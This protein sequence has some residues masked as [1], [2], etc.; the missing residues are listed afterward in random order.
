M[1]WTYSG[2]PQDTDRDL[3]RF[4]LGDSAQT[5]Q[6]LSDEE[7]D[8]LLNVNTDAA[9]H[10][11]AYRAAAEAAGILHTRYSGLSS[12]MKRVGD[13]T[14]EVHYSEQARL[15]GLLEAKLMKGRT[16]FAI[17]VPQFFDTS[18]NVFSVGMTDSNGNDPRTR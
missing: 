14:L 8:Y 12:S 2:N 18:A 9:G 17:G 5:A 3:V 15:F 6:S 7:L 16:A 1:G 13:L 10:V 4:L 11:N